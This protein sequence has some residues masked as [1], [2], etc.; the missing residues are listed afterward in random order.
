MIQIILGKILATNS[1]TR[2][3]FLGRVVL[4]ETPL[5]SVTYSYDG[6]S[7]RILSTTDSVSGV[8]TTYLYDDLGEQIGQTR[9]GVTSASETDYQYINGEWWR[10]ATQ[11]THAGAVTGSVSVARQQLT[12]LSNALRSRSVGI[13]ANGTITTQT[14]VFKPQTLELPTTHQRDTAEPSV[15]VSKFGRPIHSRTLHEV[16][17][18][19][20]DSRGRIY[21]SVTD[22]P[23]T[24]DALY[25]RLSV[26]NDY[27]DE[28]YYDS[29]Y[30]DV[31]VSGRRD[32]DI[33]G[34]ETARTDALG[35]TVTN[36]YDSLGR[37]DASSGAT[38]PVKHGY[39]TSGRA[40]SLRTT[41]DGQIWDMTQWLYD[42]ATGLGTNKIYAD[43]STVMHSYTPD[44]KP[45][46]T[47]WT[48]G[49]WKHN[50]YNADGLLSSTAYADAT[51]A[52]ELDYDAFQR[53]ASASN[54][55]ARYAYLNSA[56]GT[57]TNETA[58]VD[59]NTVTL[60]RGLDDRHRLASLTVGARS[61]HYGYD[62][63]NRL[64]TVS[65]DVFTVA[66]AYTPDG[67]ECGYAIALTNGTVLTRS[68]IR[69][70][71]R[72]NLIAAVSNAAPSGIISQ[73]SY[74]YDAL[75]RIIQ[76]N[77]DSFGYNQRSEI[78][79]ANIQP[80]HRSGYNYDYIG[81]LLESRDKKKIALDNSG[82][83][84]YYRPGFSH[85]CDQSATAALEAAALSRS[86]IPR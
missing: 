76:R 11:R 58:T 82:K 30:G 80:D 85:R 51:P 61:V 46:R 9:H 81:N 78:T 16:T 10:V 48:R 44:G 72:R 71:Y 73:Y 42:A 21:F 60:V 70:P 31:F 54:A 57:A 75:E 12:G 8:E 63:E 19:F 40:V 41:R 84:S 17:H 23:V 50:A 26:F 86:V 74:E 55:V 20:F 49:D 3:D 32:Y 35:N 45:L 62:T 14:S 52:V 66:Y 79:V 5:S 38:Y 69:D 6:S 59:E 77:N 53:L 83:L 15:S 1:V 64:A 37:R 24:S 7:S 43:N 65:N 13:A 25:D 47:T 39:D 56:L 36:S 68:V 2:Y 27:G 67:W 4:N 28:I 33:F 29:F 18:N 22:H 34:R